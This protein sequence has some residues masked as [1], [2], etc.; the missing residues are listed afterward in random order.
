MSDYSSHGTALFKEWTEAQFSVVAQERCSTAWNLPSS[1][2]HL[3]H[4]LRRLCSALCAELTALGSACTSDDLAS[5]QVRYASFQVV[6]TVSVEGLRSKYSH[7]KQGLLDRKVP[8]TQKLFQ[9]RRLVQS[10]FVWATPPWAG[11]LPEASIPAGR[12]PAAALEWDGWAKTIFP[13]KS[14]Q[15]LTQIGNRDNN[16]PPFL[17]MVGWFCSSYSPFPVGTLEAL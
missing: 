1:C 12:W 3:S 8:V 10:S 13:N 7:Y 15:C 11:R 2:H 17:V 6:R 14:I 16:A 4:L 5:C 9:T